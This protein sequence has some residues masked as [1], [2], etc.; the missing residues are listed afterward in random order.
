MTLCLALKAAKEAAL[1]AKVRSSGDTNTA[2]IGVGQASVSASS[3]S[4]PEF[5]ALAAAKKA[6]NLE[7]YLARVLVAKQIPKQGQ[8]PGL[9]VKEERG[10]SYWRVGFPVSEGGVL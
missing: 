10:I 9:K 8:L 6:L 2:R 5:A 1:V 7:G 3:T 4:S